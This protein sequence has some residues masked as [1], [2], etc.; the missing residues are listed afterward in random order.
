LTE[1]EQ[2]GL[3]HMRKAQELGVTL[4]EYAARIPIN[5]GTVD[6]ADYNDDGCTDVLGSSYLYI[7][8]CEGSVGTTIQ[9]PGTPVAGIDWDSD[10]RRDI[11]VANG[12]A[13]EVF[14]SIGTGFALTP[15][16]TS[17]PSA[18]SGYITLHNP[19]GDGQDGLLFWNT[20]IQYYLHNGAGQPPD[21]L[22][23]VT[24]GYGNS[25]S[26]TYVSIAQGVGS[27]YFKQ[28]APQYPYAAYLGPLYVVKADTDS[29][30]SSTTGGTYSRSHYYA[31]A[32]IN[33]QGRG[34]AGFHAHQIQDSRNNVYETLE[35][36]PTFPYTGMLEADY[37]T[38]NNIS[39]EWIGA[40][41]NTLACTVLSE[42]ATCT[43]PTGPTSQRY[44]PYVS[45]STT[46][47][48]ELGTTGSPA[49]RL[50][51]TAA[52]TYT[53]DTY[54]NPL[55]VATTV[56]DNDSGSPYYNDTWTTTTTNVPNTGSGVG[57]TSLLSSTQVVYSSPVESPSVT[58]NKSFTDDLTNCDYTQI[59]TQPNNPTYQV[60]ETLG[61]D[62]YGNVDSD[63]ITGVN[64]SARV[65]ST[66]WGT[67]TGQFPMSRTDP[68]GA[69]TQY[70][71]N[72]SLG[73]ISTVQDP[74]GLTT[75]WGYDGFGRK[76]LETRPDSTYTQWTYNDC[77]SSGGCAVGSHTLAL[78]GTVYNTDGSVENDGTTWFDP[79]RR[80]VVSTM[81]L[82]ASGGYSRREQHYDSLG[83]LYQRGVPCVFSAVTTQCPYMTTLA[84]DVMNRV[85]SATRPISA[86]NSG[87]DP[88]NFSH[89]GDTSTTTDSQG[90]QTTKISTPVGDLMRTQDDSGYFINFSHDAYGSVTAAHDS[91]GVMLAT[92]TY[93]YGQ[94]A[95]R[96]TLN[97]ADLGNRSYTVD[98]LG[99][100][101]SW[102]DANQNSFTQTYDT[103]SRPL[104]RT[105]P[106]LTTVWTWGSSAANHNIGK[107]QS[108]TANGWTD[109]YTYDSKARL[110][111]RTITIPSDTSYSYDYTYSATTGF[112]D[113]MTY[114]TS[115]SSYRLKL[116]YAYQNGL[117]HAIS[118]YNAPTT[119]FWTANA[120][121][122]RGELT[123][124]T[125]GNGVVVNRSLD[126]VTGLI[127]SIHSGIGGGTG[128]Q[129]Q[130]YLWD[131]VGNLIQRQDNN[132]G[133]T[134][135]FQYDDLYRI[136]QSTLGTT[137]N[138][139][140]T[141][142]SMGNNLTVQAEGGPAN[143][144]DYTTQQTGC[145]YYANSQ[146]HAPCSISNG[147]NGTI[148][149]CYDRNGNGISQL[150]GGVAIGTSQWTSYNQ[151]YLMSDAYGN[152]SQFYYD[153]NHQRWKQ[154]ATNADGTSQT[155]SYV[156]GLLEKVLLPGGTTQYRHYI[157][158]GSSTALYTRTLSG[159]S[160]YYITKDY[161][162]SP[163][164][165]T[166][167]TG[168][169]VL[170]ENFAALGYRRGSNWTGGPTDS[171]Y[172]EIQNTTQLGFTGQEMM[173]NLASIDMN[174][175]VYN[176]LG[177]FY[178]PDP[179]VQD[180]TN[181]QSFNRYAYVF[182]NP[183]TFTD[184]SGFCGVD[185]SGGMSEVVVCAPVAGRGS[186]QIYGGSSAHDP[187]SRFD[188]GSEPKNHP[189][190]VQCTDASCTQT[191]HGTRPLMPYVSL[192]IRLLGV[193]SGN[194]SG[195][196]EE[197]QPTVEVKIT[198]NRMVPCDQLKIANDTFPP[199]LEAAEKAYSEYP[200]R[201]MDFVWPFS[202]LRGTRIHSF[203]AGEVRGL[204]APYSAEVSYKNG[205]VVPY[206]T[207]G[208]I[209]ADAVV[210]P[211]GAPLYAVELK[212][213][214]A[215]PTPAETAAY[216]A[217]LPPGTGKCSI[218][219]LPVF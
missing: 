168:A 158:A 195:P 153:G 75:S 203:F 156:G 155:T 164:F 22:S 204:G 92:M 80:E 199:L 94:G 32:Q 132:Q 194:N 12:S 53:Y 43:P 113:T 73:L 202:V 79:L 193:Y 108:L 62:A 42:T 120:T 182:N 2:Q 192:G 150:S 124:E 174:G 219:E 51:S 157:Q 161:L 106:D 96:R 21:L 151:P 8:P 14:K 41:S 187:D 60:T 65:T 81:R 127:A 189:P 61:Y 135:S 49:T 138:L 55:T 123:Q 149:Y 59:V 134:E 40:V 162:G 34:F 126:D 160:I 110:Q 181:T 217:N 4:K 176:A 207:A 178:S 218:V 82:L 112:L 197:G 91:A 133:L 105:E 171:D 177:Q 188:T 56:T 183:L 38:E 45:N 190:E 196:P 18:E 63:T 170:A 37:K 36:N 198:A 212:S 19:T 165:T 159:N 145:S 206:G 11:L 216:D 109:A 64:M 86:S 71:Y 210:G 95:F 29:D 142:N 72:F 77:S 87:P 148:S 93:D 111:D 67:T 130:S 26:P 39:T 116:Q 23:N 100:V 154:V 146:P 211:I 185:N 143:T 172:T 215:L 140:M 208:S 31:G 180:P 28:A 147:T 201:P 129:N 144:L 186:L 16:A 7:S 35:Y 58:I 121:N 84:Y 214:G 115:T 166:G 173:D 9:L 101:T 13:L 83:R 17:I 114:P 33:L 69:V 163:N 205:V 152:S 50:V 76:T 24:D 6:M 179:F 90:K 25:V 85:T 48:Y 99:E 10:G 78:T 169:V 200:A 98:A 107:L 122:A 119:V 89:A 46:Y 1:R 141:Y 5:D 68:T 88:T 167:S 47:A 104:T 137:T 27:N 15:I 54:G 128:I 117:L 30:P 209:R 213:G 44:F 97:D 52:T 3:E 136:R 191:V 184:P 74:N 20:S 175:R 125:L 139:S 70:N 66:N 103:L 131:Y 102:T 57:C 118:D